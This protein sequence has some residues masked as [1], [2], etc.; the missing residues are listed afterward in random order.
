VS[1][2][3]ETLRLSSVVD[4]TEAEGP[5]LRFAIW[6]QGCTLA[7]PGCCNPHLWSPRGGLAWSVA[8]LEARLR[9]ARERRPALEGVS[10]IG[11]EPFEQDEG[12]AAFAERVHAAGLTVMAYSGYTLEELR[13]RGSRLL[14]FTDLLV[15]GRYEREQRTTSRRFVGSNNQRMHFLTGAYAP[16]DPRFAEPNTAE[17]RLDDRGEIQVVGF[18]F[19]SVLKAFGPRRKREGA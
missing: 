17:L 5:G 19:D 10:L 1:S 18:P 2:A 16:A 3:A 7:C 14:T 15:D 4:H 11:G 12:M 13:E 8:A 6:A 9:A